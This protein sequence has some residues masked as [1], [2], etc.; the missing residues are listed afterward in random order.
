MGVEIDPE[1]LATSRLNAAENGFEASFVAELP[2]EEAERGGTYPIVVA[3]ILAG[4][5]IEL[6]ELTH[7]CRV[8]WDRW[9]GL[10]RASGG[11][12]SDSTVYVVYRTLYNNSSTISQIIR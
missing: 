11:A 5:L 7:L 10:P 6:S 9:M 8:P 4:T 2:E 1:A 3:N 12:V